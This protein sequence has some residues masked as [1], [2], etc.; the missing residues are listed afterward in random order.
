MR[1][2]A[3]DTLRRGEATQ[4]ELSKEL[5]VSTR[6]LRK[7]LRAAESEENNEPLTKAERVELAELRRKA[8]RLEEENEILKKFHAFSAKRKR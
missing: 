5:G 2:L 8:K 3:I 7:W 6:T 4:A 1:Q